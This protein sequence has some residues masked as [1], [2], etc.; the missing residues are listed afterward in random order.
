MCKDMARLEAQ[1]QELSDRIT[2]LQA[3]IFKGSEKLDQVGQHV[4]RNAHC[5]PAA[6]QCSVL[7]AQHS[8]RTAAAR[9][10][11]QCTPAAA[12]AVIVS[13]LRFICVGVER[14]AAQGVLGGVSV[15]TSTVINAPSCVLPLSASHC[16]SSCS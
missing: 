9:M 2:N 15:A 13:A 14:A 7:A 5:T 3:S 10:L 12:H 4:C 8:C 6:A 16:S 1:R 11:C